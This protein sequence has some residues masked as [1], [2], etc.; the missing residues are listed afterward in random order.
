ML[1]QRLGVILVLLFLPINGPLWR[2]IIQSMGMALPIGELQF[3]GV[4]IAIFV[5]GSMMIFT[6]EISFRSKSV[7]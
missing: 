5:L 1:R 4:S 7:E 3:L 6:P 2:M